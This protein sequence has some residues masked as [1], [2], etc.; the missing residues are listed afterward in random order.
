MA[1]PL[2]HY[3]TLCLLFS[4]KSQVLFLTYCAPVTITNIINLTYAPECTWDN[5]E[6]TVNKRKHPDL[7]STVSQRVYVFLTEQFVFKT[8]LL[9]QLTNFEHN[10]HRQSMLW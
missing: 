5:S 4:S 9:C 7:F 6:P 10:V 3:T 8:C 1:V 2:Q